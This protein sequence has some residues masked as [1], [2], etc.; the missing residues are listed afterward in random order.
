[1][2]LFFVSQ[3]GVRLASGSLTCRKNLVNHLHA[4]FPPIIFS[5]ARELMS[6]SN[7]T[8]PLC[9]FAMFPNVIQLASNKVTTAAIQAKPERNALI[10]L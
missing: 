3:G 2:E 6:S 10:C 4:A 1:M 7:C 8:Y 9:N 5:P